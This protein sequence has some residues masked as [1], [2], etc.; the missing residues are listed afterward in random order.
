MPQWPPNGERDVPASE[1]QDGRSQLVQLWRH[2]SHP[3]IATLGLRQAPLLIIHVVLP[4][5]LYLASISA[6]ASSP[7]SPQFK[8]PDSCPPASR[9]YYTHSFHASSTPPRFLL[10]QKAIY[11]HLTSSIL[12]YEPSPLFGSRIAWENLDGGIIRASL[13]SMPMKE[14]T[15]VVSLRHEQK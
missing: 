1:V 8:A 4:T 9:G 15:L 2:A 3:L 11:D 10:C 14:R 7:I 13:A 5:L 12:T 6:L